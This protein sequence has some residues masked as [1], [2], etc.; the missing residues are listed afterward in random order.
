MRRERREGQR[1]K[2]RG[3]GRKGE[4]IRVA[5]GREGGREGEGGREKGGTAG[6]YHRPL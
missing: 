2:R 4:H 3:V 1:E 5:K 6:R